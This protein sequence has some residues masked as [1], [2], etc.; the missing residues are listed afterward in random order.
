MAKAKAVFFCQ[1]C[2]YQSLKWIGRCPDC[3]GWGTFS[4]EI[5]RPA[6][7]RKRWAAP[8]LEEGPATG[9]QAI[10]AVASADH[11]RMST[12]LLEMDRVLCGE[13]RERAAVF[14]AVAAVLSKDQAAGV[15][16]APL[17]V[18]LVIGGIEALGLI[19]DRFGFAA[20]FWQA[21]AKL[22]ANF[23]TLGYVIVAL[24]A[25]SWAAS[26]LVYRLRGYGRRETGLDAQ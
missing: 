23:G 16:A 15:V 18:A 13:P 14:C 12:G 2:G 1:T 25:A 17:V 4:E 9:P 10:G 3:S 6:G 21:I 22:N 7:L 11:A 26:L 24:F 8:G 5:M 19:A 20:G